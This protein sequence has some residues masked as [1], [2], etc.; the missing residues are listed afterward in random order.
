VRVWRGFEIDRMGLN[1]PQWGNELLRAM[2]ESRDE[3]FPPARPAVRLSD[4]RFKVT[5]HDVPEP[6]VYRIVDVR[7]GEGYV[8]GY[9]SRLVTFVTA[10]GGEP[11]TDA[12]LRA[13]LAL[14][15]PES[16]EG[17]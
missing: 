13:L 16:G 8:C 9:V 7:S 2:R 6:M 14:S 5:T 17:R 4:G 10:R 1:G 12:E 11:P 3:R 15:R